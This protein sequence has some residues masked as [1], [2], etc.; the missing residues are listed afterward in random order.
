MYY[1]SARMM[2]YFYNT[3]PFQ[4][5]HRSLLMHKFMFVE[6]D[7]LIYKMVEDL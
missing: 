1:M 3:C 7:D 6:M 5:K 4:Y 2:M